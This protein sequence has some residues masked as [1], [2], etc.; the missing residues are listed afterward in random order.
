MPEGEKSNRNAATASEILHHFPTV[1]NLTE[2][3]LEE[4]RN[5]GEI[6]FV[7]KK[8]KLLSA[9]VCY[10]LKKWASIKHARSHAS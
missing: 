10:F 6:Y 8:E 2:S 9:C 4:L 5:R 7:E 1:F 3:T